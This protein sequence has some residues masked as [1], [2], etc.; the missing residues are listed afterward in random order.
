MRV[1][2]V[3]RAPLTPTAGSLSQAALRY[4]GR[5]AAS[6]KSL[7]RVLDNQVRRSVAR[8]AKL[9]DDQKHELQQAIE[10]II[11]HHRKTGALNDKAYAETKI[12]S[13]RRAGRSRRAIQQHLNHK[14]V[15]RDII[16]TTLEESDDGST[17][18]ELEAAVRCAQRRKLGQ[19]RKG[20]V[21]P[22]R[23]QKD[24]VIM[25]RAGFA[26]NVARQALGSPPASEEVF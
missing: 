2:S 3:K 13:W 12:H 21:D 23:F 24:L 7:R 6:E 18:V 4:L 17:T 26:M 5:Y 22:L 15:H 8:G 25:A 19:F 1:I 11:I 20:A 9:T 14:G 10:K 16:S